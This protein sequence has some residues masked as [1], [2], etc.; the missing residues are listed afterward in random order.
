MAPVARLRPPQSWRSPLSTTRQ[1]QAKSGRGEEI[2]QLLKNG[3]PLDALVV[4]DVISRK[5]YNAFKK[6]DMPD[7][8]EV[9]Q[10]VEGGVYP[11]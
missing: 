5:E 1:D 2:R 9:L 4:A 7:A 10:L 8:D 6:D 11:I 3:A